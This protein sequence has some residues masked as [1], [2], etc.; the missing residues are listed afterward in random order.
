M[1]IPVCVIRRSYSSGG[2]WLARQRRDPF[3][4]AAAQENY[5]SRA[6]FKLEQMQARHRIIRKND[7]VLDLGASPGG[8][9]Q[10]AAKLASQGHVIG[11]DILPIDPIPNATL[12]KGDL[13]N[14]AFVS[15]LEHLYLSPKKADVI[16]SDMA[17]SLSGNRTSDMARHLELCDSVL[18][19]APT[20]LR[21][22]GNLLCKVFRGDGLD[23]WIMKE[24]EGRFSKVK[25][26]KPT[27]SRGESAEIYAVCLGYGTRGAVVIE[28]SQEAVDH[29]PHWR[30]IKAGMKVL[31][32]LKTTGKAKRSRVGVGEEIMVYEEGVVDALLSRDYHPKG[33]KV[34]QLGQL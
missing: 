9:S 32:S 14:P 2:Q 4:R 25:V 27:A 26:E 7:L 28:E 29:P 18:K 33:L 3:V 10:V 23:E 16:I 13:L 34:S 31:V 20:V 8:W 19:L 24:L 21:H 15:K 1:P 11:V 22:G 12:L 5:R 30:E 17:P 6:S